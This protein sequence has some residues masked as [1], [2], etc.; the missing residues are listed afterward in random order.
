META[1]P[2]SHLGLHLSPDARFGVAWVVLPPSLE[3]SRWLAH[4]RGRC[5]GTRSSNLGVLWFW[6]VLGGQGCTHE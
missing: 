3:S 2:A 1:Q 6:G 4:P 5:L